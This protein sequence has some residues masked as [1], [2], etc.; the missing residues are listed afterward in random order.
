MK[1]KNP[2]DLSESRVKKL[3]FG[4]FILLLLLSVPG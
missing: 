1:T 3:F 4:Y 2:A